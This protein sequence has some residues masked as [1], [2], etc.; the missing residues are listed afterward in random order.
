MR[1]TCSNF[2]R[3]ATLFASAITRSRWLLRFIVQRS[4]GVYEDTF[5]TV[6]S[7]ATLSCVNSGLVENNP[8]ENDF[9]EPD[10]FDW[11]AH[12]LEQ[13]NSPNTA[14]AHSRKGHQGLGLRV[15]RDVKFYKVK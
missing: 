7:D 13:W 8:G 12:M 15:V 3:P 6:T 9:L 4:K 10:F 11:F 1:I 5:A 2:L 14:S